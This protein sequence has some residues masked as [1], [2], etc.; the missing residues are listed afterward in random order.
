[1]ALLLGDSGAGDGSDYFVAPKGEDRTADGSVM[2]PPDFALDHG[3][4]P[5]FLKALRDGNSDFPPISDRPHSNFYGPPGEP[6]S[7][8]GL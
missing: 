6:Y 1:M 8:Q 5:E 2:A 3:F 4:S 7:L